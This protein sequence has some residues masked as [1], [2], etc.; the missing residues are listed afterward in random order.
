MK[1]AAALCPE[2]G[3]APAYT[4][5]FRCSTGITDDGGLPWLPSLELPED[6]ACPWYSSTCTVPAEY[7][8]KALRECTGSVV[9]P[10]SPGDWF[11]D[12]EYTPGGVLLTVR[13][14]DSEVT[15]EQL[16]HAFGLRSSAVTI[17]V[18]REDMT[19]TSRGCGGN[20]GM[21]AYSA[22]RLAR[23]GMSAEEIFAYFFPGVAL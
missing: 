16:R 19:F 2:Y 12:P 4:P 1:Y 7:A 11:T 17:T 8:R 5:V 6:S 15:G 21:S 20:T 3:G 23:G 13:F 9:L 18:S 14:G 10:P 22:E